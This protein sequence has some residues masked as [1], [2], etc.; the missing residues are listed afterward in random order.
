[1]RE[2]QEN[3]RT[4]CSNLI[5]V[6]IFSTPSIFKRGNPPREPTLTFGPDH[7]GHGGGSDASAARASG[8]HI[9][10]FASL[11]VFSVQ[12]L[13]TSSDFSILALL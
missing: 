12:I 8:A 13:F 4:P 7:E 2:L 6:A 1:M 3:G 5:Q 9:A 10:K 11:C